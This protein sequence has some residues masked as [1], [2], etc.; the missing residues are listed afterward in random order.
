MTKSKLPLML[1]AMVFCSLALL[2][3]S[4]KKEEIQGPKG[5]PG[6]P[7]GGGNSNM[8]ASETFTVASSDW[9]TDSA[10]FG[11]KATINFAGITKEVV[12]K[13]SLKMYMKIGTA[14]AELPYTQGDFVTQYGFDE[15]HIYL[16][17]INIEQIGMPSPP[18]TTSYRVV[19]IT[20]SS[21][22]AS[23]N[24]DKVLVTNALK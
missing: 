6:S 18:V 20:Q 8:T 5:E 1:F 12:E 22:P 2:F 3:A 19:I 17:F 4:C 11:R 24:T 15:G 7:G 16:E 21:K 23:A 13:G 10:S 9:L 14:W